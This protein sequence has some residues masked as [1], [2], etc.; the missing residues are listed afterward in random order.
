MIS[1]LLLPQLSFGQAAFVIQKTILHVY[2]AFLCLCLP[3]VGSVI[4]N[5]DRI[6][7]KEF[8]IVEDGYPLGIL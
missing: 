6:S 7:L 1:A 8:H 2:L 4:E 5:W 3:Y